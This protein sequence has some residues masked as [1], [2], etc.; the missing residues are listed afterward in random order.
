MI[1]CDEFEPLI[2]RLLAEEI[3]DP[4]RDRL[5]AHAQ[6]CGGCRQYVELHHRLLGSELAVTGFAR[7][8]LGE[9]PL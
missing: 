6:S 5:L 4:D 8:K 7:F 9:A 3:D 2:E 1:R